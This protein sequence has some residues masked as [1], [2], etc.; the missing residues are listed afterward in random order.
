MYKW[1]PLQHASM[2]L[3]T[4]FRFSRL[5][6]GC[7]NETKNAKNLF[8]TT[9]ESF[10]NLL[11]HQFPVLVIS[12]K[13]DKEFEKWALNKSGQVRSFKSDHSAGSFN[14]IFLFTMVIFVWIFFKDAN[15]VILSVDFFSLKFE[16]ILWNY[17][18]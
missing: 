7:Q 13:C 14:R 18:N 17:W 3:V 10:E 2:C 12:R 9:G 6:M 4:S 1:R 8:G 15:S 11:F 5:K 16:Y